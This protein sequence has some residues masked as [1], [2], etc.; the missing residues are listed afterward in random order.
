MVILSN[1]V[2]K[3][4]FNNKMVLSFQLQLS[5]D[6]EDALKS[7]NESIQAEGKPGMSVTVNFCHTGYVWNCL[8][9]NEGLI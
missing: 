5:K 7:K 6:Q 8:L 3:S 9:M 2:I 1:K 4:T